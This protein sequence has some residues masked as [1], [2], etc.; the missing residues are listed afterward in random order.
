MAFDEKL[1][2]KIRETLMHESTLEEKQM[3]G[4]ICFMVNGKMCIGVMKN[5]MLCRI[6]PERKEELLERTGVSEMK[7][8]GRPMKSYVLVAREAMNTKQKFEYWIQLCLDFNSK[9]KA[10]KKKKKR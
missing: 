6:A 2:N 8:T 5:E 7:F 9:A 3:F 10:S 4:G 1:A